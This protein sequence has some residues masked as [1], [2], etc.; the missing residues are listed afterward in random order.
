VSLTGLAIVGAGPLQETT[1]A[2]PADE[3]ASQWL[4]IVDTILAK[5]VDPPVRQEMVKTALQ[6]VYKLAQPDTPPGL[7]TKVSQLGGDD[8][9]QAFL[10]TTL[11]KL[12]TEHRLQPNVVREVGIRGLLSR[13]SGSQ[14]LIALGNFYVQQQLRDNRYV[15]I[16]IQL[17]MDEDKYP[18]MN[19]VF[20]RG[21]AWHAGGRDGDQMISIDGID[22]HAMPLTRVVELLRGQEGKPT[23]V[24]VRQPGTKKTWALNMVRGVVPF[25]TVLG[26]ERDDDQNWHYQIADDPRIAYLKIESFRGSTPAELRRIAGQLHA[27]G[28]RALVLDLRGTQPGEMRYV[29]MIANALLG[30][31]V[32]GH[33]LGVRG[34]QQFDS[35][36]DQ[37]F[38]GWPMVVL[39]DRQTVGQAEWIA[40]ALQDSRRA[41]LMGKPTAGDGAVLELIELP[42]G[43]GGVRLTTGLLFRR[44]GKPITVARQY[45]L[46][47]A[48][49]VRISRDAEGRVPRPLSD[50]L[51]SIIPDRAAAT[52]RPIEDAVK[53]L[54]RKLK[55]PTTTTR[56]PA[57]TSSEKIEG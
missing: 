45:A 7:A 28:C 52:R 32:I 10:R 22:A 12:M 53:L 40:A 30:K 43:I 5:H 56:V 20:P 17:M 49:S 1:A 3:I 26:T 15:G 2:D 47:H 25:D 37:L 55:S 13:V 44:S 39:I 16:G 31:A 36:A 34:R 8:E 19:K 29:V 50:S 23:T 42:N 35:T 48:A 33:V 46:Q 18:T 6:A 24:V 27:D 41:T 57:E 38:L 14:G 51:Q 21:P 11:D 4:Q 9:L 54:Q